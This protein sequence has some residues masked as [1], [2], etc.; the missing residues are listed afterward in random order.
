MNGATHQIVSGPYAG[1]DCWLD[2]AG[3]TWSDVHLIHMHPWPFP[4]RATVANK[5]M[6]CITVYEKAKRY[7]EALF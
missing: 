4:E 5:H 3:D 1:R 2:R 6:R 7:G